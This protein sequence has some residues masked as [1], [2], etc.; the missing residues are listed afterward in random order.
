MSNKARELID[1]YKLYPDTAIKQ[2]EF[3]NYECEGGI[4]KNNVA[5]IA[6]KELVNEKSIGGNKC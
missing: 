4:L 6:L 2:L 3:C 5:F 1:N